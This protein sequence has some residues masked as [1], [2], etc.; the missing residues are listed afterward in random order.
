[1]IDPSFDYE[2]Y[3][4]NESQ[5]ES[6]TSVK[7]ESD[8]ETMTAEQESDDETMTVEQESDDE[9]VTIEQGSDDEP[10]T[11]EQE[12]DDETITVEQESDDEPTTPTSSFGSAAQFRTL[13]GDRVAA[14]P[15]SP[16]TDDTSDTLSREMQT[17]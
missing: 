13:S 11:V 15:P 4:K 7:Q 9:T 16:L 8:G 6:Q 2:R 5:G 10:T 1:M 3:G 12:S 14:D 17:R